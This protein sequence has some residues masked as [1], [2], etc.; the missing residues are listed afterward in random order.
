MAALANEIGLYLLQSQVFQ[1]ESQ[2]HWQY[3][4]I[5]PLA[6]AILVGVLGSLG[7]RQLLSLNTHDL[8]R[9]TG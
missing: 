5:S 4:L 2:I 8:L 6:G 7:C 3:W 9:Q 1:M